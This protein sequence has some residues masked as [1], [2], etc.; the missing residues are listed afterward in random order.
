VVEHL[1]VGEDRE[2]RKQ[3][4]SALRCSTP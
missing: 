3:L 4:P 1:I 2:A